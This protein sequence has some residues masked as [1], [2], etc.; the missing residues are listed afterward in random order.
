M[1]IKEKMCK[2][3][4]KSFFA[5]LLALFLCLPCMNVYADERGYTIDNYA[6]HATY[7]TN[8]TISVKEVIDVNFNSYRHGIYRNIPKTLYINRD[9]KYKIQ[10]QN[11]QVSKDP[12]EVDS[13][14]GNQVIQIGD[15]DE[16]I[17]GPHTYMISY[18]LVIPEDYH[19][20]YDFM[21]YSVLG[22]NWD[23]TIDHFTFDIQFDKSLT[24]KEMSNLKV[25]S[26]N[27]GNRNNVLDVQ[28]SLTQKNIKGQ[29][30]H[31]EPNQAIT[32][33]TKLRKNYFVDAKKPV[34]WPCYV[35][36][37]LAILFG[38]YSLIRA[39][40]LKKTHI[41]PIVSFYPPKDLD[42]AMVGTIVDESVDTEDLMALIPYWASLGYLRIEEKKEDLILHKVKDLPSSQKHQSLIFNGLF[43]KSDSIYLSELSLNFAKR[44]EEAKEALHSYFK[45]NKKLSSIDHG[46][47]TSILSLICMLLCVLCNT[48]YSLLDTL[49]IFILSLI[50]FG[51]MFILSFS[52]Q[53]SKTF[54][55]QKI[56]G[57]K[58]GLS[59]A[60]VL[61][62]TYFVYQ[63]SRSILSILSFPW[64]LGG[65]L[66]TALPILCSSRFSIAS[67]YFKSVAGELLGFK[68]FIEKA[69]LDQLQKLSLENPEYYYDVIP[70][71]M[72][73]GLSDVWTKKFT[74]IPLA[75][76]DWYDTYDSDPYTSYFYYRMLTRGMY[77]PIHEN[78]LEYQTQ[79]L[80]STADSLGSSFGGFSG[81]GAGGGGGGSW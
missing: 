59:I 29:A 55:K 54:T 63:K 74:N 39:L 50:I 10:I 61:V 56:S 81:G 25:Y 11:I 18:N 47:V 46:F 22:S 5:L 62:L 40:C 2:L 34:V 45:G 76:P 53:A 32:I 15:S 21:Y 67:N 65:I 36:L 3:N 44:M 31:L 51:L 27:L 28:T 64:I 17:I 57:L 42:P 7:H 24:K 33:F 66:C 19:S 60:L 49:F 43:E 48:K 4:F 68:D 9:E 6:V 14:D 23:T 73:F 30:D 80:Q 41:T 69:E 71:A 72:V 79:Q 77:E 8:N 35:C 26:G 58:F 75:R 20:N 70:Y 38:V 1:P 52:R 37:G 78:L 12:F 13:E 16:T